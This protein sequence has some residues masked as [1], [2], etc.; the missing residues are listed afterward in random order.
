[1][2]W[3][4]DGA[5]LGALPFSASSPFTPEQNL[6]ADNKQRHLVSE[7][8]SAEFRL[9]L[10]VYYWR[11][12][13]DV[14]DDDSYLSDEE[15]ENQRSDRFSVLGRHLKDA[16]ERDDVISCD[17]LQQ[18]RSTCTQQTN[19]QPLLSPYLTQADQRHCTD[20][21][22][23]LYKSKADFQCR[24]KFKSLKIK[25]TYPYMHLSVYAF[26]EDDGEIINLMLYYD[27]TKTVKEC[28][29][30]KCPLY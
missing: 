30:L 9:Y 14:G 12:G 22:R 23:Y 3:R 7:R 21:Q 28:L 24:Y 6:S 13:I 27:I 2:V 25:C 8:S 11:H 1:M 19:K 20:Q 5:D 10:H 26:R 15:R 16:K 4:R 17:C 29:K 18:T